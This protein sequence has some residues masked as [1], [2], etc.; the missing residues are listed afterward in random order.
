MTHPL[1]GQLSPGM[2]LPKVRFDLLGVE[3]L[4]EIL[5]PEGLK[6][7]LGTEA[8]EAFLGIETPEALLG[9]E[10]PEAF[11]GIEALEA[12]LGREDVAEPECLLLEVVGDGVWHGQTLQPVGFEQRIHDSA[13]VS[14]PETVRPRGANDSIGSPAEELPEPVL[15][16][17]LGLREDDQA[18]GG[19]KPRDVVDPRPVPG[20]D[21]IVVL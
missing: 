21:S 5:V 1:S 13:E 6:Y 4:E 3:V 9:I 10:T 20:L 18:Q 11:L 16:L 14:P 17:R 2:D 15:G 12:L 19:L 8:P 7:I